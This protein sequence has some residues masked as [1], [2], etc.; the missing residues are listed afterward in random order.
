MQYLSKNCKEM[1]DGRKLSLAVISS[2]LETVYKCKYSEHLQR[3]VGYFFSLSVTFKWSYDE[4][5]WECI[6]AHYINIS[7]TETAA[8]EEP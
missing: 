4:L 1:R 5:K 8:T 6:V 7:M 2:L 3:Q